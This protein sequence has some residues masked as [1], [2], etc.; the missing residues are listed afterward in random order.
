M[1]VLD[2]N[3]IMFRAF[4]PMV[5]HRFV[6]YIDNIPAFMVKKVKAP[7]FEDSM[8]KLDHINS[9][10]KIRGKREWKA[11]DMTL[12]SPIT[13]SG[14]QA[15]M[16]WARLGYESVTGRAGY[17]DFYKKDLTLNILGPVGDI[18]GEWIIKGAFL[19]KGDFGEFDWTQGEGLVEIAIT[20]EMDYCVLNY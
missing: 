17:S 4:E 10:R 6:M 14:A 11:M 8:I 19:T 1:A 20:V 18:V 3:E 5:Q 2:P 13:P 15:V 9:Y 16:E 12:Y 7:N